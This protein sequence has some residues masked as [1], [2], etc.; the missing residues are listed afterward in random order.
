M[1][2]IPDALTEGVEHGRVPL[3]RLLVEGGLLTD[4]QLEDILYEG[5]QTGERLGEVAVRRGMLSEE[6]L[7]RTLAE[8]WSLSYVD[9]ASIFFDAGA[10]GSLSREDAQRLEAMPTRVQD[11]RIVV[12]VAEPTEPRLQ[13]LREV[14]GEDTVM[15]VVPRAAL[16]AAL[17]SELLTSRTPAGERE[18]GPEPPPKPLPKPVLEHLQPPPPP[19]FEPLDQLPPPAYREHPEPAAPSLSPPPPLPPLLAN[20]DLP[21]FLTDPGGYPNPGSPAEVEELR[22]RVR[23]LEAELEQRNA[24]AFEVQRHLQAALRRLYS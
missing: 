4:A 15:V 19:V 5:E 14:I 12:A 8:Q 7:A 21:S 2:P 11:G 13:A 16:D 1:N 17:S 23:Q 10:L 18:A 3:G 20:A 22:L 24:V 6:D 9:R